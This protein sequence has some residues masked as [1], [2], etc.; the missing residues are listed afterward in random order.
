MLPCLYRSKGILAF[1]VCNGCYKILDTKQIQKVLFEIKDES[2]R[3]WHIAV[4]IG[5][6]VTSCWGLPQNLLIYCLWECARQNA[7]W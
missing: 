3:F 4:R 6:F 7:T 5:D 2:D 1:G